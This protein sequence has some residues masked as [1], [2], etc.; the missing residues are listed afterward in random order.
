MTRRRTA[1]ND[2]TFC[3]G[4]FS[5]LQ[6]VVTAALCLWIGWSALQAWT[7]EQDIEADQ[8]AIYMDTHP[9]AAGMGL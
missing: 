8:H 3:E 7:S 1:P 4:L 9:R 6:I 2:L 5:A